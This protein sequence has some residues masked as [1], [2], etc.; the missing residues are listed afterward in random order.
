M[1]DDLASC[2]RPC[3]NEPE[4]RV[5]M[6]LLQLDKPEA[7]WLHAEYGKMERL[8]DRLGDELA[9]IYTAYSQTLYRTFFSLI[10][11]TSY[12]NACILQRYFGLFRVKALRMIIGSHCTGDKAA[13]LSLRALREML[14]FDDVRDT[15]SFLNQCGFRIDDRS[16][17]DDIMLSKTNFSPPATDVNLHTSYNIVKAKRIRL[18]SLLMT[19]DA[20][21][22]DDQLPMMVHSSFSSAS[23]MLNDDS[24][25]ASDRSF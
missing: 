18:V 2:N 16:G 17:N 19:D 21:A 1:Y 5:Y 20:D 14:K 9:Q 25:D 4:F 24:F 8:R 3:P 7:M 22:D 10:E 15:V 13:K 6:A 12:L 23:H 11:R